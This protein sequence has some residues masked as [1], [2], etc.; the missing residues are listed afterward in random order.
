MTHPA[1]TVA[2]PGLFDVVD[3]SLLTAGALRGVVGAMSMTGFRTL[4]AEL[5][6]LDQGTPPER[7]AEEAIPRLMAAVPSAMRPGVLDLLH[8]SYGGIGGAI[9]TVIPPRWRRH[10][11]SGPLFG[12]TL[13][14]GYNTVLVPLLRLHPNRSRRP[15]EVAML[16]MDHL[17]YGVIVGRLGGRPV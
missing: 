10:W 7:M 13:W 2:R 9:Y 16:A 3:A 14:L 12:M 8:L 4:A 15:H 17:L 1:R 11:V 5:G 6:L